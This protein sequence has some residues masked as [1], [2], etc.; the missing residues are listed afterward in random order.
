MT[1]QSQLR[2]G[3]AAILAHTVPGVTL[4]LHCRSGAELLVSYSCLGADL[5]PCRLRATLL[6]ERAF[7]SGRLEA[8]VARVELVAG[9][10]PLGAGLYERHAPDAD[11]RWFVTTLPAEQVAGALAEGPDRFHTIIKPD[12]ELGIQ[13]VC[14]RPV[15]GLP[16]APAAGELDEAAV[17]AVSALLTTQLTAE[18][19]A[20]PHTPG[21]PSP[22]HQ[23]HRKDHP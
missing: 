2:L 1:C 21:L 12:V 4:R 19:A 7:A 3:E 15:A 14:V 10:R 9:L 13:A 8:A 6:H 17:W 18:L 20:E 11:E 16:C 22:I 23:Q 5:D